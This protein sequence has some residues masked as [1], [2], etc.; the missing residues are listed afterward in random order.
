MPSPTEIQKALGG[1][2]YPADKSTLVE[3]AR[4]AGAS[5]DVMSALEGIEDRRYEGPNGVSKAVFSGS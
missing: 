1:I 2:D 4:S 5:D 3:H